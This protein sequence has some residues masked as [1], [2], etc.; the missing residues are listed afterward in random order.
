[1]LGAAPARLLAVRGRLGLG[2]LPSKPIFVQFEVASV[3]FPR[4]FFATRMSPPRLQQHSH[5]KP[6]GEE[7]KPSNIT[8]KQ[9]LKHE[10][11]TALPGAGAGMFGFGAGAGVDAILTA[12]IGITVVF[13]G[14]VAYVEWYKANVLNKIE[15]AFEPGYDPALELANQPGRRGEVDEDGRRDYPQSARHMKRKEQEIMDSIMEGK[16]AGYYYLFVGPK[17]S[18]K[19]TMILDAMRKVNAD[20]VSICDAH[21]DLEVFRLRLGK[22]L[23]YEY[24]ED[25]QTGLFQRRDPREGG[26]RLDI[27][28]ALNK[29]EK[30]AIRRAIK[31]GRPLVLVIN[32]IHLFNNDDEGKQLLTQLQQRA[33]RWA[34]SGVVTMLFNTDDFWPYTVMRQLANRM[35]TF[36]VKDLDRNDSFQALKRLRRDAVGEEELES[37]EVLAQAAEVAGKEVDPF[38]PICALMGGEDRLARSQDI[39][40][41]SERLKHSEKAWLLT[42]IGLI[43]DFD[44][45]CMDE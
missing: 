6:A 19:T 27:E 30:V 34:E 44:D 17:G 7:Q 16:E 42:H 38:N 25:S 26:P 2:H 31:T 35:Q 3:P 41:H 24:N 15:A 36:S 23:N 45:D 37:D 9:Q 33:E 40:H 22:T 1:M 43:R 4:A 5:D 13:T 14:G 11:P 18:G 28:R 12:L 39:I 10:N 8:L 21:Q 29:L 20:S 32:D